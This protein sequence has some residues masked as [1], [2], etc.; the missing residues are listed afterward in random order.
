MKSYFIYIFSLFLLVACNDSIQQSDPD[1]S[2]I[3]QEITVSRVSRVSYLNEEEMAP[4]DVRALEGS[5][6]FPPSTLLYISQLS[7]ISEPNFK[8]D[9]KNN[10]YVFQ[11]VKNPEANWDENYNFERKEGSDTLTWTKIKQTGS[12]GNGFSLYA[13]TFPGNKITFKVNK[14]QTGSGNDPYDQDNFNNSDILGAYHATST[15]FTRLRFNLF[16]LMTYLKVTLYVPDYKDNTNEGGQSSY[17][18]YKEGALEA[19]YVL[20]AYENFTIEWRA[21]RSSDT[22]APLTYGTGNS[23]SIKMYMHEPVNDVISLNNVKDYFENSLLSEDTVRAYNFSVLFPARSETDKTTI[24]LCFFLRNIDNQMKYYYF[25][26]G[27]ITTGFYSPVQ[28][29]LQQLYLYLDRNDNSA[30][31]VG[32]KILP[33]GNSSTDM[34]VTEEKPESIDDEFSEKGANS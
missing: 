22:E 5:S 2:G 28:G 30:I 17:S 21:N 19:G 34:T 24:S 23:T 7:N 10:L 3:L 31:L 27:Q 29:T 32:A 13:M 1:D 16:H 26:S 18:G 4:G 11:Y 6:E 14:D 15:L 20:N 33:W 9:A 8:E 12:V 25:E